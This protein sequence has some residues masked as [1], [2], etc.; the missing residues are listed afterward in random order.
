[1]TMKN[2][3]FWKGYWHGSLLDCRWKGGTRYSDH[4]EC[5][6]EKTMSN[7]MKRALLVIDVQNDYIG[8]NLPI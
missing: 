8:G 5:E 3:G 4:N 1:M 7:S 6:T 2:N